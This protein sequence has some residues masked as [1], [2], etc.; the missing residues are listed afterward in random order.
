MQNTG[1]NWS[2]NYDEFFHF[3]WMLQCMEYFL[4]NDFR[5]RFSDTTKEK[6]PDLTVEYG[7]KNHFFA[8]CYVYSKW[9][10]KETF[11][12]DIARLI[13]P[14]LRIKQIYNVKTPQKSNAIDYLL[15]DI[16]NIATKDKLDIAEEEASLKSPYILND[17]GDL[18]IIFEGRG[19]SQ[20]SINAHGDPRI[21]APVYLNEIVKHKENQNDLKSHRPNVL[22]VN[23]LGVDFQNIFFFQN[24]KKLSFKSDSLDK[25]E[26]FSCGIDEKI[27]ECSLK[28]T[29]NKLEAGSHLQS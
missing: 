28:I 9:W 23:G 5:V 13:H 18:G 10:F 3:L 29:V 17:C 12:E 7:C 24:S 1:H 20:P 14:S 26:L 11:L 27:C 16:G 15:N 21:S 2:N 22:M 19:E 4:D 6:R 8:E 25:V